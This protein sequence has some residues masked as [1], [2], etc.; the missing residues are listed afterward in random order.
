MN[1]AHQSAC[2]AQAGAKAIHIAKSLKK[3]ALQA[4]TWQ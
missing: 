2:I 4:K 3:A 1:K